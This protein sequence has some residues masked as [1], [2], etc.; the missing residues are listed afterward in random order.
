M[1][2]RRLYQE[3][4]E[5]E[6]AMTGYSG[7]YLTFL[8]SC[9]IRL[10]ISDYQDDDFERASELVQRTNQLNFSG[11]KYS[12]DQIQEVLDDRKV[13]KF[14]LY[15]SDKFGSYGMVGIGI[16]ESD[17]AVLR[18]R[19]F[20]LSCRVQGKF[21]EQAF[22]DWI[23]RHPKFGAPKRLWINFHKTGKNR[24][25]QQVLDAIRFVP[26]EGE[27]GLSLDLSQHTLSCNFIHVSEHNLAHSQFANR[28]DKV[29]LVAAD[30]G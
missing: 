13:S 20:M 4:V 3:A 11:R 1:G 5:R 23:V 12:R 10:D 22:F 19:D 25:A 16:V 24:P 26:V 14:M 30:A 28:S 27:D 18:V 9:D 21:V 17:G 2:R 8:A 6:N 29:T 15:C 7:D